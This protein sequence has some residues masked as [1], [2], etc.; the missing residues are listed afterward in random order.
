LRAIA[1]LS[2]S[3]GPATLAVGADQTGTLSVTTGNTLTVDNAVTFNDNATLTIG[4][5]G[6][7]GTVVFAPTSLT[8]SDTAQVSVQVGTLVAGNGGL[9]ELTAVASATTIAS[10]ATLDFQ[11]QTGDGINALFGAGT[12]NIGTSAST[13]LTVNSGNFSGNIAGDGGLVKET[14]GTLVLS[15]QNAFI[16]GTTL[17]AGTLIVDGS[18]SFGQGNV[19]MYGGTLGGSGHVGSIMLNAGTVAPGGTLT[20]QALYWT[21][22]TLLFDLGPT[23]PESDQLALDIL[24]GYGAPGTFYEFTFADEGWVVGTPYTLILFEGTNIDIA[25][26]RYTNKGGFAGTFSFNNNANPTALQFTITAVPEPH[27][28]AIAVTALLGAAILLRRRKA[29]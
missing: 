23:S 12:V 9:A 10:G 21:S 18:L 11:D 13:T 26:F 1:N 27:E 15:G 24:T 29:A 22:G 14:E 17:N 25:S 8:A 6:N 5:T 28:C 20:A 19:D 4:S 16:G 2:L 3:G 7:T